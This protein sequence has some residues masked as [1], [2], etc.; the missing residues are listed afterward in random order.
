[1]DTEWWKVTFWV[2]SLSKKT[3]VQLLDWFRTKLVDSE[4]FPL[5]GENYRKDEKK[6]DADSK[7]RDENCALSEVLESTK[8]RYV[9]FLRGWPGNLTGTIRS[10]LWWLRTPVCRTVRG[11]IFT[12]ANKKWTQWSVQQIQISFKWPQSVQKSTGGY[13]WPVPA[14]SVYQVLLCHGLKD[15]L[16]MKIKPS[17]VTRYSTH[18]SFFYYSQRYDTPRVLHTQ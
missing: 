17:V 11:I 12:S 15:H 13:M 10:G 9:W 16:M 18:F 5:F 8:G 1:M 3:H 6:D 7:I 2:N 14:G 4:L